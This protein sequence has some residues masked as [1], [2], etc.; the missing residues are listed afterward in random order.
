M[1]PTAHL[2][3]LLG[4]LIRLGTIAEV[5]HVAAR[6]RVSSGD[7]LTAPLPWL[8]AR[9]GS[10]AVDWDAPALGEQVLVLS[11][12]GDLCAGIVLRGLYS[13]AVPAP[14]DQPGLHTV[15]FDDGAVIEYD[16]QAHALR[17]LLPEGATATLTAPGGFAITG[18]VAIDGNV[19][20][21]G[22]VDVTD[23]VVADGISLTGHLHGNVA[24]GSAKTGAPE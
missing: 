12:G 11:P 17:A 14:S 18:D 23:D 2:Q 5:D 21:T 16:R 9:A 20:V 10:T 3:R 6:C 24:S 22:R 15:H 13:D 1:D 19:S 7:L 8:S 4:N